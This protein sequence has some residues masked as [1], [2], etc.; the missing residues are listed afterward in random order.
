MTKRAQRRVGWPSVAR[1]L[2]VL[3]IIV[4]AI[5]PARVGAGPAPPTVAVAEFDY[6]DTSGEPRDQQTV[7][8]ARLHNFADAIRA[9]LSSSG[10]YKVVPL[11]CGAD[12]CPANSQ[13]PQ[14][15]L[16]DARRAGAQYLLFGGVHKESTLIG[17]IKVDAIETASGRVIYD[18]LLTFRGDSEDA[19]KHAEKFV[20]SDFEQAKPPQ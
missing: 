11:S 8:T 5:A 12:P 14:Q 10:H 6:V 16:E 3:A 4:L 1:L 20:V 17:W 2:A 9:D 13:S 15:L 18:R 19:W 7:H